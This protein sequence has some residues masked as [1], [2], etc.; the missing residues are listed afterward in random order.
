[1]TVKRLVRQFKDF[2]SRRDPGAMEAKLWLTVIA[3]TATVSLVLS[4]HW[5]WL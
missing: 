3:T 5:G 4:I 2:R 1:M